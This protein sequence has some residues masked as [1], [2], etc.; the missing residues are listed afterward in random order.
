MTKDEAFDK[1]VECVENAGTGKYS[2][3]EEALVTAARA[4]NYIMDEMDDDDESS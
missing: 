3:I 2:T 1:L 4:L